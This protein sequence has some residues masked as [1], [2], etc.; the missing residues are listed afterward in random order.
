V[1]L[2]RNVGVRVRIQGGLGKVNAA[3][4]T[5][6]GGDFV[7]DAYGETDATLR[8]DVETGLGN[9]DLELGE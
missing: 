6:D 1:R 7:N 8:V 4:L 3:G 2:P 9:I 5:R